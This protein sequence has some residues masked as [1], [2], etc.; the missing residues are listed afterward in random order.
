[1]YVSLYVSLSVCLYLCQ[2][3]STDRCFNASP[4]RLLCQSD[5]FLESF[6]RHGR[7]PAYTAVQPRLIHLPARQ[8]IQHNSNEAMQQSI[9]QSISSF[10]HQYAATTTPVQ[11]LLPAF[12]TTAIGTDSMGAIA[13]TT[14]KLWGRCPQ[15]AP[16]EILLSFLK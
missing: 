2:C 16:T 15:V 5:F 12:I 8:A 13:S 10:N 6:Q 14:K 3:V 9:N 4:R 11:T 7:V 1:M